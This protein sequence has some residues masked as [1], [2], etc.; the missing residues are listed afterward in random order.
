MKSIVSGILA[1]VDAGKT[2][3]SEA[4]LFESGSIRKAGRVDHKDTFL[5][6]FEMER[7][8][9]ITIF[10]KQAIVAYEDMVMTL[11][12]TP[13]HVDFSAEMERTLQVLDYA[14]LVVSGTD[15]VQAHTE[16]L[17]KLLEM[18]RIPTFIF[19]NKMDMDGTDSTAIISMLKSR[20]SDSCIDFGDK[21]D[22]CDIFYENI[23]MCDEDVLDKYME[24]GDVPVK[25]I[26]HMIQERKVFPVCFGSAL[27][28][29][30]VR[31]LLGTI[32]EFTL[33]REH[34]EEFGARV[35]KISRDDQ[36]ARLTHLKVT[37]GQLKARDNIVTGEDENGIITEKVNQ[38][39]VY[40]GERFETKDVVKAGEICAI[41]GADKTFAGQGIGNDSGSYIPVLEP[42]L[43]YT[44]ELEEEVDVHQAYLKIKQLEEEEP[45]LHIVWNEHS[46][47]IE[48]RVMGDVQTEV[49]TR[50]VNQRFGYDISFGQGS[51]MYKETVANTVEGVGH[52]EPLRHYAEVHVLIE[53]GERGSGIELSS[54]CSEDMLDR[55]WQRLILTHLAEKEH[56]GILTGSPL[57]DVKITLIGGKA[58]QKHTEGGD[59]RQATYRSVR[60]G[61]KY[62]ENVLLEP[63]YSFTLEVP[64]ENMGRAINDI[65]RMYG[66][67]DNPAIEGEYSVIRGM[68]PVSTM[69][70]YV[71]EVSR[72]TKGRG[73][74]SCNIAGY[75]LCHNQD[76]IVNG[77]AY[78]SESDT[79]NPTGSVFCSHGAGFYVSWDK[80]RDYMHINTGVSD[81]CEDVDWDK[82]DPAAG[83]NIDRSRNTGKTEQTG[84]A[85][86]EE[87]KQIFERTFGAVKTKT[88]AQAKTI[89]YRPKPKEYVYKERKPVEHYLLVD[90]YNIIFA[91]EELN[92][93]S[94]DNLDAARGKL[95]D[96]MCNYQ[97]FTQETVIVV[98][99]AYK[100]KNGQRSIM[101][102][103]NISVVF[104]KE[105]ETADMYI[106]KTV[107]KLAK[108]SRITVATSDGL[109]Q[110]I[111]M[112]E[113]AVRMSAR[114][115]R[116][117][118]E[119]LQL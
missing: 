3:L 79:D 51:I 74:L 101:Q 71:S 93:L 102:Y 15:G 82:K 88:P 86:E 4:L 103:N 35:Y 90:G 112:G 94:K 1:H 57:T 118:I 104:T 34:G 61:L 55:N 99:D 9:G 87:L 40:S 38:I 108:N 73:R 69:M 96:I 31:E 59:F 11:V 116:E 33:E 85:A 48:V 7:D 81:K 56:I 65:Q 45:E 21:K 100:V 20:L 47:Q 95:L 78:D 58:H 119:K 72:Y 2:T 77:M 54:E 41:T 37:G 98:F 27:K 60:Q 49:I 113:G 89:K 67:F 70:G 63:Y 52:F 64:S 80:V 18:Y 46:K 111:I 36:G 105:A 29:Q 109:E 76:E 17:W 66:K 84:W 14:I 23:A 114:E 44:I 68:A 107:H 8:R 43:N 26:S 83:F 24:S 91:W 5:D 50:M 19:V 28:F 117:A 16:T 30:G 12:D 115:L 97:G 62:A 92:E 53:P 25:D 39:R 6:T 42:V 75:D 22:S 106:E 13:G 110:M 32:Y 10:S